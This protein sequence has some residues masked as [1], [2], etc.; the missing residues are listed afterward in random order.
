[1]EELPRGDE[2]SGVTPKGDG[3]P[4]ADRRGRGG[5]GNYPATQ[6]T[7]GSGNTSRGEDMEIRQEP[8]APQRLQ[9]GMAEVR[10]G[11]VRLHRHPD[12]A[13]PEHGAL[14]RRE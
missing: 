2:T 3:V 9:R 13:M 4:R 14:A 11:E 7:E 12:G 1:M 10:R 8:A 5:A 6:S